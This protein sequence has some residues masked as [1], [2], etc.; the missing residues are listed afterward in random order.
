MFAHLHIVEVAINTIWRVSRDAVYAVMRISDDRRH[1]YGRNA[2]VTR[3]NHATV[4]V[5]SLANFMGCWTCVPV[6]LTLIPP[7]GSTGFSI[8]VAGGDRTWRVSKGSCQA[9]NHQ[10]ALTFASLYQVDLASSQPQIDQTGLTPSSL[11]QKLLTCLL[12]PHPLPTL[13]MNLS[14]KPCCSATSNI[15]LLSIYDTTVFSTNF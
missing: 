4:D 11:S 7:Y 14:L 12:A 8:D 1:E 13:L 10:R 15:Q 3:C 2:W 6:S 5:S 9:L